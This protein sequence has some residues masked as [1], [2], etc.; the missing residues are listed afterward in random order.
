MEF[1]HE[2]LDARFVSA[3]NDFSRAVQREGVLS[4]G[5]A[6]ASTLYMPPSDV[7]AS[8]MAA[9]KALNIRSERVVPADLPAPASRAPSVP[10]KRDREGMIHFTPPGSKKRTGDD[11]QASAA[12]GQ[13]SHGADFQ[14]PSSRVGSSTFTHSGGEFE[15]IAAHKLESELLRVHKILL[16]VQT[17]SSN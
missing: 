8:V 14:V 17:H 11:G 6:A 2:F 10:R 13:S 5:P 9:T 4:T 7:L 15:F 12:L 3:V 1:L 16:C